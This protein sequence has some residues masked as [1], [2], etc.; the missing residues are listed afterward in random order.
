MRM[1]EKERET[2]EISENREKAET[3]SRISLISRS[4]L[5]VFLLF[6]PLDSLAQNGEGNGLRLS[7]VEEIKTEFD[8]VP[9]KNNERLSAVRALFEKMGADPAEI[10]VEKIKNVENLI[11]QLP[12]ASAESAPEKIIIGAH[13]D[14][15]ENGCGAVDNWTG[16]VAIAHLYRTLKELKPNKTMLFVA[17]GQEEKGLIGSSAMVGAIKKEEVK[18]YCAMINIDSLGLGGPQ[19]ADNM[20]SKKMIDLAQSVAKEM[21]IP[22]VHAR[23]AEA[24][25]DSSSFV[26]KKIPALTIHSLTNIWRNI[27]HTGNDQVKK[28]NFESVYQGYRLALALTVRIDQSDC[29][30]FREK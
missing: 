8:N 12:A 4:L 27:L 23:L 18:E 13:Y 29:G 24:D 19:V 20:S 22:F 5:I 14:K 11:V 1:I 21:N 10:K 2:H 30:A 7:S 6:M 17:F 16:V 26:R 9:C 25:S 3:F 28:V 15:T